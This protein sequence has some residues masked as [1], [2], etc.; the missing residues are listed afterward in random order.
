MGP[1]DLFVAELSTAISIA[2]I[3][4]MSRRDADLR[5]AEEAKGTS[6]AN[7]YSLCQD[8][9]PENGSFVHVNLSSKIFG[10]LLVEE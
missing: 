1:F 7:D 4:E 5:G 3:K 10:Y 9:I 6:G 2:R 8:R